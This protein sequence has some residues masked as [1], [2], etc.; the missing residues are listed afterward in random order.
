MR[1]VR[2]TEWHSGNGASPTGA[3]TGSLRSSRSAGGGRARLQ[4]LGLVQRRRRRR[5]VA[6]RPGRRL[7]S[8]GTDREVNLLVVAISTVQPRCTC[9]VTWRTFREPAHS[10]RKSDADSATYRCIDGAASTPRGPRGERRAANGE[11]SPAP[12]SCHERGACCFPGTCGS[13]RQPHW[14]DTPVTLYLGPVEDDGPEA[15]GSRLAKP[16]GSTAGIHDPFAAPP[17]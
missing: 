6:A 8:T 14:D 4:T 9:W 7:G 2:W 13:T 12:P 17:G 5:S 16:S 1:G 3:P 15:S 11:S 10:S